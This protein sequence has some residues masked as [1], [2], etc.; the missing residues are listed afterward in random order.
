M[1]RVFYFGK[2]KKQTETVV[3]ALKASGVTAIG[4]SNFADALKALESEVY[5]AVVIDPTIHEEERQKVRM[6]AA[7]ASP[8]VDIIETSDLTL[9][10]TKFQKADFDLSE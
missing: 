8:M 2:E 9:L 10:A 1:R 5:D 4:L 6:I 3:D 7:I